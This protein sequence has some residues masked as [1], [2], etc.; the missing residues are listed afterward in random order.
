MRKFIEEHEREVLILLITILGITRW[1]IPNVLGFWNLYGASQWVLSYDHGLIRRGLVGTIMKLWIPIVTIEDVHHSALIAYCFFLLCL[2]IAIYFIMRYKDKN[3]RLF[4]I[5]LLFVACPATIALLARNIGRFDLFLTMILFLSMMLLS[6]ER[7]TW[8]IPI[9]MTMAMF[10]HESFLILYAPTIVAAFIFIYLWDTK[11]KKIPIT[12]I[13]SV[14]LVITAFFVLY[15]YGNPTLRLEEFSRI[16][17]SRA[18]FGITELSMREC[19]FT[20]KDHIGLASSSFYD[21][22]S[23][24]NFIMAL[25]IL[26]PV[27]LILLNLWSHALNNCRAAHYKACW[28]FILATLSGLMVM[29]IATDY[30]RWLSAILFCN[31]FA[32]FFLVSRDVIKVEELTEYSGDSFKLLFIFILLTYLLFGPFHDWEPYPYRDNLIISSFFIISILLFD[33]GFSLRWRSSSR[34]TYFE[35]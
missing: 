21:A 7:Y 35:E 19:Y 4:R 16:I 15:K 1:W 31:F 28:L 2:L 27:I 9:F 13:F 32:I 11:E 25:I 24:A 18:A 26:S 8:L 33:I 10:I 30:G 22:G 3:G 12:L 5:I 17:Q 34:A 20:I 14:I 29:P 23:I 6:I